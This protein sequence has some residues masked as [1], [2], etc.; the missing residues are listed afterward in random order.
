VAKN[1]ASLLT[2][3]PSNCRKVQPISCIKPILSVD[4]PREDKRDTSSKTFDKR[5]ERGGSPQMF[6]IDGRY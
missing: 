6:R 1:E 3:R 2:A 5:G 4:Q